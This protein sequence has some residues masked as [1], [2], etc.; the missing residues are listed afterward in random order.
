MVKSCPDSGRIKL[1]KRLNEYAKISQVLSLYN[2]IKWEK[3]VVKGHPNSLQKGT[4]L[5]PKR[6]NISKNDA[7][8][9]K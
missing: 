5:I 6:A 2:A 7:Q 8:G 4:K 1:L 9:Q 3:K